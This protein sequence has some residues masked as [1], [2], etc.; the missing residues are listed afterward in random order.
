MDAFEPIHNFFTLEHSTHV[1]LSPESSAEA[2]CSP[3]LATFFAHMA[4]SQKY[5]PIPN[6]EECQIGCGPPIDRHQKWHPNLSLDWGSKFWVW[7]ARSPKNIIFMFFYRIRKIQDYA[8]AKF[9]ANISTPNVDEKTH[10]NPMVLQTNISH[11][12]TF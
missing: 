6:V 12:K 1:G 8:P 3:D 4:P 7:G 10:V 9:G 2:Q 11:I 5:D